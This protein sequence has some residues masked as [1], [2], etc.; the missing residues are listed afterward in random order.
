MQL[1]K[2]QKDALVRRVM[3]IVNEKKE[4]KR[5]ELRKG[6]KPSKEAQ[7]FISRLKK[8]IT[9]RSNFIK[10]VKELG[11]EF[12]MEY[13]YLKCMID[14][15][16]SFDVPYHREIDLNNYVE[17]IMN[18]DLDKMYNS[19]YKYPTEESVMDDLELTN[20]SKSFDVDAFLAKYENL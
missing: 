5:E 20:L 18:S 9:I 1:T 16:Y 7:E 13:S 14:D 2:G 19:Q 6:Y 8:L 15:K 12:E 17:K 3:T 10:Q 4:A 11:F